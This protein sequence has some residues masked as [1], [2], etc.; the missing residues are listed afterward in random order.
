[1]FAVSWGL[2][3]IRYIFMLLYIYFQ[4]PVYLLFNQLMGL[5][6]SVILLY[7]FYVWTGRNRLPLRWTIISVLTFC[8]IIITHFLR[9]NFIIFTLP[10]FLVTGIIYITSGILLYRDKTISGLGK[11][12]VIVVLIL[13]GLHKIDYPFLRPIEWFAPIGYLIGALCAIISAI[14]FAL[15]YFNKTKDPGSI[16]AKPWYNSK[17]YFNQT[18]EQDFCNCFDSFAASSFKKYPQDWFQSVY[19]R[20][21]QTTNEFPGRKRKYYHY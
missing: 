17:K 9:I 20:I 12:T 3:S 21:D 14:G 11:T 4:Q 6:S 10:T 18:E 8:W 16:G 1:M 7:G 19:G 2:Y 15:I 5:V 13:W